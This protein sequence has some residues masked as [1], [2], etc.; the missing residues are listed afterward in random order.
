MWNQELGHL[1]LPTNQYWRHLDLSTLFHCNMFQWYH[2]HLY[3]E[4]VDT[5]LTWNYTINFNLA[6]RVESRRSFRVKADD[7]EKDQSRRSR[8]KADDPWVKADDPSKSRRSFVK[9]DDLLGSKQ[10]ILR[11]KQTIFESKQTIRGESRRSQGWK[12]TILSE[13][14]K[15][16][17]RTILRDESRRSTL[18]Y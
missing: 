13:F 15:A 17:K 12:R 11:S 3:Y 4:E 6:S 7:P 9:A 14:F 5:R 2:F 18:I 10:T 16:W 1:C 8:S